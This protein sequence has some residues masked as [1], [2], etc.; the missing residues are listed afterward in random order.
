MADDGNVTTAGVVD[1]VR[2]HARSGASDD[3]ID[4]RL[5]DECE[6]VPGGVMLVMSN[7]QTFVVLVREVH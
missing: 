7:G 3:E 1:F 5:V 6:D 4:E 2:R